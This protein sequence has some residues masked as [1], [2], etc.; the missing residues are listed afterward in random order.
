MIL[1]PHFSSSHDHYYPSPVDHDYANHEEQK[2]LQHSSTR[3]CSPQ[4][5][6]SSPLDQVQDVLDNN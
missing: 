4:N 5:H 6:H 3:S 2:K 1:P